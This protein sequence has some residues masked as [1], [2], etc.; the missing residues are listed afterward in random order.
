M[1]TSAANPRLKLVRRLRS[2]AQR[3]R[4]GLFVC[5]GEDLVEAGV[6]A[7][8]EPV[9]LLLAGETVEPKLLAA[10]STLAHPPRVIAVFRRADLPPLDPSN[11]LLLGLALW[12]VSDPGNLGTLIR[13][14]DAF[15]AFVCLSESIDLH[16]AEPEAIHV[17]VTLVAVVE[18]QLVPL[19]DMRELRDRLA[20]NCRLVEIS[21][22]YGHDAFLKET[23][24]LRDVFAQALD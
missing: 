1:I 17:P 15:E 4:L 23:D 19:S 8:I 21:S 12:H 6:A 11:K 18:D 5:E 14:A 10:V 2:K 13:C 24:V 9:D 7:G 3:E 16:R 20:G 22:L